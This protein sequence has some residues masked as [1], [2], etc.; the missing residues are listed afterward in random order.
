MNPSKMEPHGANIQPVMR[1]GK[2]FGL[3]PLV[4]HHIP[5]LDFARKVPPDG[6]LKSPCFLAS[7]SS[8]GYGDF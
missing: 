6:R 7:F 5:D 3:K 1:T 8:R 4:E 2:H